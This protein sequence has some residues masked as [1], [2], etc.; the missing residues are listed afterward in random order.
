MQPYIEQLI[1]DLEWAA[2]NPLDPEYIKAPPH[3]NDKPGIAELARH[4]LSLSRNRPAS[5]WR[6][7]RI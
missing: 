7:F 5:A 4:G 3:L 1:E 2:D 6:F